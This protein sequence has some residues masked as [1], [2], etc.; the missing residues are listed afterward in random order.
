MRSVDLTGL[1]DVV[2][3]VDLANGLV[4]DQW[5]DTDFLRIEADTDNDGVYE[6]VLANFIGG[7]NPL[8]TMFDQLGSG[9]IPGNA[10]GTF[11]YNLPAGA[12][13]TT[14]RFVT[15]S[16]FDDEILGIDNVILEG[17][18]GP[19]PTVATVIPGDADGDGDVDIADFMAMMRCFTGSNVQ[20]AD[21]CGTFDFDG[22]GDIDLRDQIA[23]QSAFTGSQ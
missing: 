13:V 20:A 10:W 14:I 5:E 17:T 15:L 22:D 16:S 2:L 18:V 12:G 11:V 9:I 1:V 3:S 23:W 7:G 19:A 8:D 21:G 4:E 6:T